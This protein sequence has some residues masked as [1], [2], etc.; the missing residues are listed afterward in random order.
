MSR[1]WAH[2][3]PL[4]HFWV[5]VRHCLRLEPDEFGDQ[6]RCYFRQGLIVVFGYVLFLVGWSALAPLAGATVAPGILVV[7]SNRK[8]VQH[9][10]GGAVEHILVAEGDLA[11]EGQA[12]ITLDGTLT[13]ASLDALS[14]EYWGYLARLDRL[15]A[16]RDR[17]PNTHIAPELLQRKDDIRVAKFIADEN[18]VFE[19]KRK[20]LAGQ[21]SILRSRI[22][23]FNK[24]ISGLQAQL[25]SSNKQVVHL[26]DELGGVKRLYDKGYERKPRLL[27]LQ[28]NIAE[29]IGMQGRLIEEISKTKLTIGETELSIND[30]VNQ[31][32]AEIVREM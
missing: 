5:W 6:A 11:E 9:L 30:L 28:R 16:E 18:A 32:G 12:L 29:V 2:T 3:H 26:N 4:T 17:S 21:I 1:A 20:S 27:Q 8:T 13:H 19:Q 15:Q 23:Q 24:V 14:A 25:N 7:D 10:T 22:G 31:R